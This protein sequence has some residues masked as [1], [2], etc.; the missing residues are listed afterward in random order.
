MTSLTAVQPG[1]TKTVVESITAADLTELYSQQTGEGRT[2]LTVFS[3]QLRHAANKQVNVVQPGID[4]SFI[5]S[6]IYYQFIL[7]VLLMLSRKCVVYSN[8]K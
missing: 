7:L 8:K 5:F 6:L 3:W 2:E 4:K 1:S